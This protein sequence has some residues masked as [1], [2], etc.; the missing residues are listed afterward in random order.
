[1]TKF[2]QFVTFF[3]YIMENEEKTLKKA[4]IKRLPIIALIGRP[5]VGKSSIFNR[6][7][8]KNL[9]LTDQSIGVTRDRIMENFSWNRIE[10]TI[11]DTGGIAPEVGPIQ[12]QV[13]IQSEIALGVADVILFVVDAKTGP[14]K[15][16]IYVSK[17]IRSAGKRVILVANKADNKDFS[18]FN[19]YSLGFAEPFYC[20]ATTGRNIA[21]LL[22]VVTDKL[23][24]IQSEEVS[25]LIGDLDE[26]IP[27][28][29][30]AGRPNVGKSSLLNALIG[31]SRSTV[32]ELPGTTRDAI[33]T[34][35][36]YAEKSYVLVDTAGI[37]KRY[38]YK[39]QLEFVTVKRAEQAIHRSDLVLFVVDASTGVTSEDQQLARFIADEGKACVT[40]LNKTDLVSERAELLDKVHYELRFIDYADTILV[41]A[42]TKKSLSKVF[43][44]AV[45]AL[46][47]YNTRITTGKLNRWISDAVDYQSPNVHKGKLLKIY[48]GTQ[49]MVKPPTFELFVNEP[50]AASSTYVRFLENSL[51]RQ[52][53]F[54]GTPIRILLRLSQ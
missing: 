32:S 15:E 53:G 26:W 31:E 43:P 11:M 41:S 8:G 50:E 51:R 9:V 45:K 4:E 10:F 22:D 46:Q 1:M 34:S 23:K 48:Y 20:S 25:E 13:S 39:E 7:L 52:F 44:L 54:E 36:L 12:N 42:L 40:I 14:T 2:H 38:K 49:T 27:R 30:I 6:M 18:D 35:V 29:T 47:N 33:D 24:E 3:N 37:K 21:D 5:S 16:D 17:L 19:F 28:I